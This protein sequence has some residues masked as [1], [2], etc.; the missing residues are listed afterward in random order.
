MMFS[1]LESVPRGIVTMDLSVYQ[2]S[3]FGV[4]RFPLQVICAIS[5]SSSAS[6]TPEISRVLN[7]RKRRHTVCS[8]FGS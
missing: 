7:T 8:G 5:P 4:I 6:F 1:P 3:G 2:P